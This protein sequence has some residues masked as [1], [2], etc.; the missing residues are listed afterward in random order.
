MH[1]SEA[2]IVV[3]D[4]HDQHMHATQPAI[5]VARILDGQ[6]PAALPIVAL[7]KFE[8]VINL[9]T[10]KDLGISIPDTLRARAD[11]LVV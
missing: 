11:E 5:Y 2:C 10:G 6:Q 8:L 9:S 1:A 4:H 3:T 7:S